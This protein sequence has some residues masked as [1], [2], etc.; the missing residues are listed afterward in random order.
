MTTT[1]KQRTPV[2]KPETRPVGVPAMTPAAVRKA[3]AAA[4]A[5]GNLP[6]A[7]LDWP[8]SPEVENPDLLPDVPG[9]YFIA[10]MVPQGEGRPAS[11]VARY[12]GE[13]GNIRIETKKQRACQWRGGCGDRIRIF[14]ICM[15]TPQGNED[16]DEWDEEEVERWMKYWRRF[17]EW[18]FH[19]D[20]K[21]TVSTATK[22]QR[23][24]WDT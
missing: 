22:P 21:P 10:E 18:A 8:I 7:A 3:I 4:V 13:A 16:D 6:L 9:V 12:I 2:E 14:A 17:L 11:R 15:Q 5:V 1:K 19:H 20:F 24:R 23:P